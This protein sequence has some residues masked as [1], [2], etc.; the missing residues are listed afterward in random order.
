VRLL[1]DENQ[2]SPALATA[3]TQLARRES[4]LEVR[5]Q[6]ACSARRLPAA[7]GLA[8]VRQLLTHDEDAADNRM[9]L[10]LWWAIEAK[11]GS[12]RPDVLGLFEDSSLWQRPLVKQHLL[13]RILRRYA[14]AGTRQDLLTCAKLFQLSPAKEQSE[15]L[16]RG[17]EAAFQGRSL[18][19]L[20]DELLAGMA[21]FDAGSV[22]LGLRQSKPEAITKALQAIAD[23]KSRATVRAQYV[24]I[25]GEVKI[26]AA[27][28]VLLQLLDQT[29]DVSLQK[30]ALNALQAYDDAMIGE[31]VLALYS[32]LD[33]DTQAAA[34]A[35]LAS[36]V[37]WS[38][39]WLQS[40]D[41]GQFPA[42]VAPPNIIRAIKLHQDP[43]VT[44]LAEKIWGRRARPSTGEMD[45][46]INRLATV[47][48]SGS[49]DPYAGRTVFQ[50]TCGACHLLFGK[51]GQLGP[52][53][54]PYKRDDVDRLLLNIVNPSAEIREGYEYTLVETNDARALSGFLVEKNDQIV[55]L[56]GLDGQNLALD[57]RAIV[58]LE[59]AGQS[60]MPEG[61][62][63][64]QNDQQIRDLFA[65]LCSSQP[66]VGI[67]PNR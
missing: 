22:A 14:Q 2:V 21:R 59:P 39:Q 13:E 25:F 46:Q 1:A 37:T 30:A 20:P 23:D 67:G 15:A 12:D 65:Y 63:E 61:L 16:L 19:G 57:R 56:R 32:R 8:I 60:L 41:A 64:A 45:R 43:T 58:K 35:L 38:R 28:P 66:L 33:R 47:I 40:I 6:L 17:F 27:V 34:Q 7:E 48:R 52:D 4:N 26:P 3:I 55:V 53:L 44:K 54:T 42:N 49:G 50:N 36:R 10:H 9:P 18:T 31:R 5:N 62:L 24:G 29:R 11:A 51:G